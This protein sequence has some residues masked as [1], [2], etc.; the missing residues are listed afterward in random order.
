MFETYLE[1][2]VAMS[3]VIIFIILISKLLNKKYKLRWRYLIWLFIAIRLIIPVNYKSV[4][5]FIDIVTPNVQIGVNN[6][7]GDDNILPTIDFYTSF[8]VFK[9]QSCVNFIS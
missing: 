1:I 6:D 2:S 3:I 9:I 4:N 5:L 8:H 7:V